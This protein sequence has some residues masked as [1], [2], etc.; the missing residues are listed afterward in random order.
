MKYGN[1]Q[2]LV[3]ITMITGAQILILGEMPLF[4]LKYIGKQAN[5]NQFVHKTGEQWLGVEQ[6]RE[7]LTEMSHF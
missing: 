2:Y 4:G 5:R 1:K 6:S 7:L 3:G